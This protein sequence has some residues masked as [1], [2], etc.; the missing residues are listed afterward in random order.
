MKPL[1]IILLSMVMQSVK[2]QDFRLSLHMG[3]AIGTTPFVRQ[4]MFCAEAVGGVEWQLGMRTAISMGAGFTSLR[5]HYYDFMMNAVYNERLFFLLPVAV[6]RFSNISGSKNLFYIS[7]GISPHYCLQDYRDIRNTLAAKTETNHF[8]GLNLAGTAGFGIQLPV[9]HRA[10]ISL[11]LSVQADL[12][13]DYK[14]P[15]DEIRFD[16]YLITVSYT[17]NKK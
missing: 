17:R 10:S 2:A 5:F 16:K 1:F 8:T 9:S 11:G 12:F 3:T 13:A 4:P 7:G 6:R 15:A 14:D